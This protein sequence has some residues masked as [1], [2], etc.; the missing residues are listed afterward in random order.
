MALRILVIKKKISETAL[1][2]F[3]AKARVFYMV[4][5]EGV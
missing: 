4:I 3:K 1:K 5:L 2:P